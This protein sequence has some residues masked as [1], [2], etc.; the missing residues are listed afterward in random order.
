MI[1]NPSVPLDHMGHRESNQPP[2]R[3]PNSALRSRE[4]LT[5]D[6]VKNLRIAAR[7]VGRNRRRDATLI[8]LAYRH[9][10]RVSEVR[11]LRWEQIDL[12]RRLLYVCRL[13]NGTP[14]NHP[15]GK[16]ECRCLRRLRECH[17]ES[18]F[19]FVSAADFIDCPQDNCSSR[20]IRAPPLPRPSPHA[21]PCVWL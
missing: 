1:T 6:E 8:L 9:G 13:K 20:E 18:R 15:L 11:D 17:P 10:L 16:K 12:K 14:S 19:L 21:A 7:N 3:V 5:A 4:Y 2:R